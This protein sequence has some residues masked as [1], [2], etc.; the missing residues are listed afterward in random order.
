MAAI[1]QGSGGGRA[2]AIQSGSANAARQEP[3]KHVKVLFIYIKMWRNRPFLLCS[4]LLALIYKNKLRSEPMGP[5]PTTYYPLHPF[6]LSRCA[7]VA[8]AII[9]IN[10]LVGLL[11]SLT[12]QSAY[13]QNNWSYRMGN[14][15]VEQGHSGLAGVSSSYITGGTLSHSAQ[16]GAGI[17][18]PYSALPSGSS[19]AAQ[20]SGAGLTPG[21]SGNSGGLAAARM[22]ST[23]GMAG[24]YMRSD[25]NPNFNYQH[26]T[27]QAVWRN[28]NQV[29]YNNQWSN[30]NVAATYNY[31]RSNNTNSGARNSLQSSVQTQ[32]AASVGSGAAASMGTT[33]SSSD[34]KG[35]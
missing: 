29:R 16:V 10:L 17:A 11:L 8:H 1:G 9:K 24:D 15:R 33:L 22:G 32:S 21:V 7:Q 28:Q 19:T 26:G 13:S 20:I 25:L 30:P 31:A 27:R 4:N 5:T 35:Y 34:F 3:H 2:A 23:V 18:S 6:L 14:Q 12:A